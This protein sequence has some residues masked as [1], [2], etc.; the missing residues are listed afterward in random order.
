VDSVLGS[1]AR[2]KLAA[3][4]AKIEEANL[5]DDQL[6]TNMPDGTIPRALQLRSV[7]LMHL[8]KHES[9]A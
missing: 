7:Q 4:E 9:V 8:Q 3:F 1:K 5:S 2:A 6:S